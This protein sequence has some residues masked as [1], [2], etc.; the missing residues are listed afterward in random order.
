MKRLEVE[1]Q[2]CLDLTLVAITEM[3]QVVVDGPGPAL[4]GVIDRRRR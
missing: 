2:Q 4:L 3:M 1:R